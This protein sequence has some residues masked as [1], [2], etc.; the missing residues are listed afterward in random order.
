MCFLLYWSHAC[1][2]ATSTH[3]KWELTLFVYIVRLYIKFSYSYSFLTLTVYSGKCIWRVTGDLSQWS[4]IPCF[5][6]TTNLLRIISMYQSI[7]F[8]PIIHL[9]LVMKVRT[10]LDVSATEYCIEHV[11]FGF[12][13]SCIILYSDILQG[14][15]SFATDFPCGVWCYGLTTC[16]LYVGPIF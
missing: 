5:Q 11:T 9:Y 2:S 1:L 13:V 14:S 10:S 6:I 16:L 3:F 7:Y 8:Y 4:D 15:S 12:I